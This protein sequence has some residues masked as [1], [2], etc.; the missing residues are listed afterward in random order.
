MTTTHVVYSPRYLDHDPG[1]GHPE[2]ASR[3]E[4]IM[5]GLEESGILAGES[6]SLVDPEPA[7]DEELELV[8]EA[9][10]IQ[11]VKRVCGSGGGILDLGDTVVSSQSYEV[12]KLAAGGVLKGVS[13]VMRKRCKNAFAVVR[14]PGHHSGP[15][16]A[17]GFCIF[18]NVAISAAHLLRSFHLDRVL[19][20]DID[21][22]HGN[23]TQE[24]FYET[25]KVLYISLHQDPTGF[26]GTG[27]I[28]ETGR[29]SGL[30]Y[31]VNIPL[32][33]RTSDSAYWKA[34]K[35][36]VIPIV[37]QYKPQFILISAGFDGYYGDIVAD[38]SLSACIYPKLFGCILEFAHKFCE[39]RIAVV[40]EGGYKLSFLKKIVTAIIARM[41]GLDYEISDRRPASYPHVQRLAE[42][43]I[44][45]VKRTQASYWAL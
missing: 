35:E 4:F 25:D 40:L 24:I 43:M 45:D 27:F 33:F 36:V 14:P 7:S 31:T 3:L 17:M 20:L 28:D 30:G 13:L 42:K 9:D 39:D 18:N 34:F 16:Y 21:A 1:S 32:P 29:E 5:K 44:E 2:S 11:L 12:A 19:I 23:G 38:L 15:Y 37:N 26:P 22:H 6:C 8:H 41:S 10:Y